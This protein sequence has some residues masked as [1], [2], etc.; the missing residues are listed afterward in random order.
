MDARP[1]D[2][3]AFCWALM[4]RKAK[5]FAFAARLF[6]AD[7]RDDV[8]ALYAFCR[9]IDDLVD[10]RP[11]DVPPAVVRH[12]LENW[13][14]W[15][16]DPKPDDDPVRQAL[17]DVFRRRPV[18]RAPLFEL[19]DGCE[20]DLERTHIPDEETLRRYCYQVAGTVGVA[21]AAL[22]GAATEEARQAAG[23]LGTA[24]Q[25]TNIVRDVREDALRGRV[26]LPDT[27]LIEQQVTRE[28]VLA[29]RLSPGLRAVL[30]AQ[31]RRAREE[32]ALGLAGVRHLPRRAR[33]PILI[34]GR[35]YE[36]ILAKIEQQ[37]FDVFER[38]AATSTAE[39]ALVA[40][41]VAIAGG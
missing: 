30:E 37:R 12:H 33:L 22:L 10:E 31:A 5:T 32:Y 11:L 19:I 28:D 6:P 3:F 26:Y 20:S 14:C 1:A 9:T 7:V 29:C 2:S 34:A 17:A 27:A 39:K 35:L 38:R 8:A 13:R 18:P 40:L 15:L 21:M 4:R 23:T 25:R 36:R 16:A 24:M 41:R